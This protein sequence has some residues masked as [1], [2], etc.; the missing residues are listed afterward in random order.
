MLGVDLFGLSLQNV[1]HAHSHLMFF[2]WA[3]LIP[4]LVANNNLNDGFAHTSNRLQSL[5]LWAIV[6]LSPITFVFF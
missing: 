5:A 2:G 6:I 1:R 4:F 3:G